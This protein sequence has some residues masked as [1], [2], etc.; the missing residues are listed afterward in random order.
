M[1]FY[2]CLTAD[3]MA[4]DLWA[5]HAALADKPQEGNISGNIGPKRANDEGQEIGRKLLCDK[6]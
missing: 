1:S 4:G 6:E 2:V 3:E 5:N